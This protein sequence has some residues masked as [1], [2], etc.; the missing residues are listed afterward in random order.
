MTFHAAQQHS[1]PLEQS[2]SGLQI[3]RPSPPPS[4]EHKASQSTSLQHVV[5]HEDSNILRAPINKI[6]ITILINIFT[7]C[8][9]N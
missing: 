3:P 6:K 5:V 9:L 8:S 1:P 2:S 4:F 7:I